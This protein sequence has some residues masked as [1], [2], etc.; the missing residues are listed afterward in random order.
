MPTFQ[1][2]YRRAGYSIT[3]QIGIQ[4]WNI[5]ICI[6]QAEFEKVYM[7][8]WG[9]EYRGWGEGVSVILLE[10]N[11]FW[12][13]MTDWPDPSEIKKREEND[14]E[15]GKEKKLMCIAEVERKRVRKIHGRLTWKERD[16]ERER[17]KVPLV[18]GNSEHVAR[19]WM[20]IGLSDKKIE[21]CTLELN[22]CLKK[23]K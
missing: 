21:F 23:I 2:E 4:E 8:C 17:R 9:R 5:Q 13:R 14:W 22:N 11:Y 20:K 1:I 15:R 6:Y 3:W 16:N 19:A 7:H 10:T 18:Y 12:E